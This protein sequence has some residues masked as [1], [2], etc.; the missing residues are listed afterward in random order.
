[1]PYHRYNNLAELLN[2]DLAEKNRLGIF[3]KDLLDRECNCSLPSKVNGKCVYE[4]KWQSKCIIYEVKGSTC[5]ASYIGNTQQ[6]FK[7]RMD[8]HFSNLQR[9]LKNGQK[10]DSFA[11]HFVQHF[12]STTSRTELRKCMT[13]KVIKQLNPIGAM[14]IFTKPNSNLCMQ[15]RLTILKMIRDKSVTVMNNNLEAYVA[16]RHKT[17]FHRFCLSTDDPVLNGWKG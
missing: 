17:C 3:S 13:F 2:R 16:C 4:G 15:E 6:T 7:K 8:G 14:K 5:E 9:L 10:S 1:M 12:N 11:T